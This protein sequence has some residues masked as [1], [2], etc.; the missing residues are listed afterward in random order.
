MKD[1][2]KFLA[3]ILLLFTALGYVGEREYQDCQQYKHCEL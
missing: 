2:I 3:V 1:Y